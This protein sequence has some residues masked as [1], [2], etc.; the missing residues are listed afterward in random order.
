MDLV[1]PPADLVTVEQY[2]ALGAVRKDLAASTLAV[3]IAGIADRHHDA[4]R[5]DPTTGEKVRE[6]LAG[7]HRRQR[8]M[9]RSH[10][11]WRTSDFV[12]V[13]SLTLVRSGE[14]IVE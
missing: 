6:V 8:P 14:L 12:S 13:G 10:C 11:C 2:I 9:S 4:G 1:S 7:D 3:R 5:P